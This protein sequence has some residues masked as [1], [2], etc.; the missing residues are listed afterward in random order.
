M[1][2]TEVLKLELGFLPFLFSVYSL[3]ALAVIFVEICILVFLCFFK[4]VCLL[5]E[6]A[7]V[8]VRRSGCGSEGFVIVEL[9]QACSC[10]LIISMAWYLAQYLQ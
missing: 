3:F 4:K 8:C 10:L 2:F 1:G 7:C 5:G 9:Y 6:C